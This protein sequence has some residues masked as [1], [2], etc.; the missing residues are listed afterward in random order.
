MN[1]FKSNRLALAILVALA[2]LGGVAL[3]FLVPGLVVYFLGAILLVGLLWIGSQVFVQ[4]LQRRKQ[5]RFDAGIAAKEGIEDRK[6]EWRTWTAEL[7]Q[8]GIDRYELPFYLLVGEPQSGKSVLLQNSDLNFPFGQTRLSGIGGTR[9]CDWWFTEEAVILDLAG[10][11][12]THEGGASDEAEWEAFL[13]LLAGYRPLCPADGI[14]LV[15]PCD[16]L[17]ADNKDTIA[18][19]AGKIRDALLTLTGKLMA[20][21]PIYVVLTKGDRIFGFAETVHRLEAEQRQQMFGW[22][23]PAENFEAPFDIVEV[24]RAFDELVD[25]A[26]GLRDSM[27][28]TVRLPEGI[29][30]VDRM[31]AFPDE[32]AGVGSS[33]EA[34]LKGIFSESRLVDRLYF[35]GFYLTSGLQSGKPIANVCADLY[36]G[37]GEADEREL[38]ALFTRQHAYF[39]KDLVR[40][41]VFSERGLVRP[42]E[43][44]VSRS[45]RN[46]LLGYGAAA[47]L[48]LV[49]TI[50][51]IYYAFTGNS[52]AVEDRYGL[53]ISTAVP[54]A[55]AASPAPGDLLT[56]L[57]RAWMAGDAEQVLFEKLGKGSQSS[58]LQ[59]Y[60]KLY[61]LR[62][63]PWIRATA[64]SGLANLVAAESRVGT[65]HGGMD[66]AAFRERLTQL[67][68]LL[69]GFDPADPACIDLFADLLESEE[70]GAELLVRLRRA[71]ERRDELRTT[72]DVPLSPASATG[73]EADRSEDLR[74][75]T[76]WF[77]ETLPRTLTAGDRLQVDGAAGYL[78][79]WQAAARGRGRLDASDLL[80]TAVQDLEDWLAELYPALQYLVGETA[81]KGLR[82]SGATWRLARAGI[83]EGLES[84]QESRADLLEAATGTRPESWALMESVVGFADEVV[85]SG[86]GVPDEAGELGDALSGKIVSV[87]TAETAKMCE[88]EFM[89]VCEPGVL[90]VSA[91]AKPAALS[92]ALEELVTGVSGAEVD[93]LARETLRARCKAVEEAYRNRYGSWEA[94][95]SGLDAERGTSSGS[96]EDRGVRV[97]V[98]G[99]RHLASL[100]TSLA[101]LESGG[102]SAA[103]FTAWRGQLVA[104]TRAGLRVA[105]TVAPRLLKE[106]PGGTGVNADLVEVLIRASTIP[107]LEAAAQSVLQ[108]HS[109]AVNEALLARW[110]TEVEGGSA[111]VH[112]MV[113]L[114]GQRIGETRKLLGEAGVER[115]L[116]G[117]LNGQVAPELRTQVQHQRDQLE[118]SL[119]TSLPPA[120]TDVES[121][122]KGVLELLKAERLR[123]WQESLFASGSEVLSATVMREGLDRL[124]SLPDSWDVRQAAIELRGVSERLTSLNKI[125]GP[126]GAAHE[127]ER[128]V[129]PISG[130]PS[131][132]TGPKLATALKSLRELEAPASA[133]NVVEWCVGYLRSKMD[134]RAERALRTRYLADLESAWKNE[135][136]LRDAVRVQRSEL[137]TLT[138]S[139]GAIA[140]DLASFF[141]PEGGLATLQADYG[142]ADG[143]SFKP[144]RLGEGDAD[145]AVWR[146][147]RFLVDLGEVVRPH[148]DEATADSAELEFTLRPEDLDDGV[149]TKGRLFVKDSSR[150]GEQDFDMATVQIGRGIGP[151]KWRFGAEGSDELSLRWSQVASG[152]RHDSDARL[153]IGSCLAPLILVWVF[154]RAGD[155]ERIGRDF[156]L[157]ASATAARGGSESVEFRVQFKQ[158]VPRRCEDPFRD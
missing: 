90:A 84:L 53:A 43:A 24:R 2:V 98:V 152:T 29:G 67:T 86:A 97:V 131:K 51:C 91:V 18:R 20:Q 1:L 88:P 142:V 144:E 27:M 40:R 122:A 69:K 61:D 100:Y 48:A 120:D 127:L 28:C 34:Y 11:L 30:E 101:A 114:L 57:D 56:A 4:W 82:R 124:A 12:F 109:D 115:L 32:F 41:R 66:H 71:R 130:L 44:R 74:A 16:S 37:S 80:G 77:R 6:S 68:A 73:L 23:R 89:A 46:A 119:S 62:L 10:R 158:P 31:Y 39:I 13:E 3:V 79:A 118:A 65:G 137:A 33:L 92:A 25:R 125:T 15:I 5:Q 156:R 94:L 151:L 138:A 113:G 72:T 59:L 64:E 150:A 75:A 145:A 116:S 9:G 154:E 36:G 21:L 45:R 49:S 104:M 95:A 83:D 123:Q 128:Q 139:R 103:G 143:L 70:I 50:W 155:D 107:D 148:L 14:M 132:G 110:R 111:K 129:H 81:T 105:E 133:S 22:S 106:D 117:W 121:F 108:V 7:E 60:C 136:S 112:G 147:D 58:F 63:A 87:P 19:K 99:L 126:K 26:R 76:A 42:T 146:F 93:P 85:P 54:V 17:L 52:A 55:N 157:E 134:D 35:R 8:Q 102:E 38:E 149:W 153:S 141:G 96:T 78:V 47:S 140:S 135:T